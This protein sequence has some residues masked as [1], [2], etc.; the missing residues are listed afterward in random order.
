[1][2]ST[3]GLSPMSFRAPSAV[4][5][6]EFVVTCASQFHP[7]WRGVER[8]WSR[9]APNV[10]APARAAIARITLVNELRTG[11]SVRPR[12]ASRANRKPALRGG[13]KPGAAAERAA[14][15]GFSDPIRSARRPVLLRQTGQA[16]SKRTITIAAAAPIPSVK[17]SNDRPEVGSAM[18]AVPI[19]INVDAK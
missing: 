3:S 5:L 13:G 14:I 18:R 9:P 19:G 16:A 10:S 4:A 11:T 8:R 1:M 15:E 17:G 2:L 7:Y 12:P 6:S